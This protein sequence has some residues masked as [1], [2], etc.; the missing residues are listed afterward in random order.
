MNK[1][2]GVWIDHRKAV[3]V[4]FTDS[5]EEIHSILSEME[6]HVRSTDGTQ[7]GK[8]DHRFTNH[9][10]E[11]YDK[12]TS[13]VRDADSILIFGPGE[14]KVELGIRMK[15]ET[16]G[17]QIAGIETV[18]KMTDGQI[19]AKVREHFL[20]RAAQAPQFKKN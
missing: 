4:R 3:I 18:D 12:V 9:L 17:E 2:A 1:N 13:L 20:N 5:G 6:K 8:Q 14:A 15:G 10:N 11:Y 16:L 19:T 7:E